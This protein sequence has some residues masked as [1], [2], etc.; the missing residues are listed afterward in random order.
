MTL[1]W[2]QARWL[3]Y[4]SGRP[5]GSEVVALA[6][7]L[8]RILAEP[9]QALVDLPGVDTVAMDGWAVCGPG[10]WSMVG[11]SP[12]GAPRSSLGPG[13]AVEVATG[14]Q[15]PA[16]A[17]EV[18]RAEDG[19]LRG[20]QLSGQQLSGR[21]RDGD[22]RLRGEQCQLGEVVLAA[23]TVLRPPGVGLAAAVGADTVTVRRRPRVAAVILGDEIVA[24]GVP[25][26]GQVRDALGPQLAG[27]VTALGGEFL[28][29]AAAPDDLLST[30]TAL[31]VA[32]EVVVVTGGTSAG[33]GD[34]LRAALVACGARP[35]VDGVEVRPGR[36]MLLHRLPSGTLVL[37]LPGNP[38]AA[39]V[40]LVTLLSPVL[41][42][43]LGRALVNPPE[44]PV[45]ELGSPLAQRTTAVPCLRSNGTL[46]PVDHQG[47]AMLRGVAH[48]DG[49]LVTHPDGA[50]Q[51]LAFP[52]S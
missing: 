15:C 22:V 17:T 14:S 28:G 29:R 6:E 3:A 12:A 19:V 41:D 39:I 40:A 33:R 32:A 50:A 20:Q 24:T 51:W 10:P 48:A 1:S 42:G 18:V 8:G 47:T 21:S 52:W 38:L 23:G 27:W 43:C 5:L 26:A 36:P 44:L 7:A 13:E 9:V 34:Y 11:A 2:G 16:G 31:D 25:A 4:E 30:C 37:G 49:L 35:I 45:G 46:T